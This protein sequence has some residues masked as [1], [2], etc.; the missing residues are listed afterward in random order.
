MKILKKIEE[1]YILLEDFSTGS[2]RQP[3]EDNSESLVDGVLKGGSIDTYAF[4]Y[5]ILVF[6]VENSFIPTSNNIGGI[7][8]LRGSDKRELFEYDAGDDEVTHVRLVKNGDV[9]HGYGSYDGTEWFSAG[10]VL[11]PN[12]EKIGVTSIGDYKIENIKLYK[13]DSVTLMSVIPE[14]VVYVY[15]DD[16]LKS[17]TYI[18]NETVD[19]TFPC[20]PFSGRIAI[21]SLSGDIIVDQ[22]VSD[23]WGGDVYVVSSNAS[24]YKTDNTRLST[25]GSTHLGNLNEGILEEKYYIKNE[26]DSSLNVTIKVSDYSEFRDWV[27]LAFDGSSD[28]RKD[29]SLSMY[30]GQSTF[31]WVHVSRPP[32][33]DGSFDYKNTLCRFFL[34]VV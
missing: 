26:G 30:P 24:I 14:W 20:Y 15:M 7:R 10:A 27:Y 22:I 31:F 9:Y 8:L 23:V 4:L 25:V 29:L 19:I 21:R 28:F 17:T 33:V 32:V 11:F 13:K 12:C 1:G 2:V 18:T 34:E 6:E 5:D 3:L 16:D